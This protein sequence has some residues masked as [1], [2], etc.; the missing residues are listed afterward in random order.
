[1]NKRVIIA[2]VS[3]A[4]V[5]A[6]TVLYFGLTKKGKE[7]PISVEYAGGRYNVTFSYYETNWTEIRYTDETGNHSEHYFE[8]QMRTGLDSIRN[9]TSENATFLCW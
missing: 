6:A 7:L 1:M 8:P 9:D 5:V 3:V 2:V 4:V